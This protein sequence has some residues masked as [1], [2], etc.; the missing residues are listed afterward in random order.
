MQAAFHLIGSLVPNLGEGIL[1]DVV[2]A[3][4]Q[5]NCAPIHIVAALHLVQLLLEVSSLV[6]EV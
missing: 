3:D 1:E 6:V 4:K 5:L 2:A